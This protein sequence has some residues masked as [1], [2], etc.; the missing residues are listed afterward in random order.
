MRRQSNHARK[1]RLR[2]NWSAHTD[3]QPQEAAARHMFC[4][5]GLQR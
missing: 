1:R 5:G 2:F 4:S 3:S